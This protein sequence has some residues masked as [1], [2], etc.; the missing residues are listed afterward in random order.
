MEKNISLGFRNMQEKLEKKS[1]CLLHITIFHST[2]SHYQENVHI[3]WMSQLIA[4]PVCSVP[5][6]WPDSK[7]IVQK[8]FFKALKGPFIWQHDNH[9]GWDSFM[10]PFLRIW[11]D[12]IHQFSKS[13]F[14]YSQHATHNFSIPIAKYI[15]FKCYYW[16]TLKG[17]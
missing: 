10:D 12:T 5:A 4:S 17:A 6:L 15:N 2:F 9:K 3:L 1:F 7:N 8:L 11:S 14:K 16:Y 13:Q